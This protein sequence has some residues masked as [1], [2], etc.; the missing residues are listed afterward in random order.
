MATEITD[1]ESLGAYAKEHG[2][3]IPDQQPR[4]TAVSGTAK[5]IRLAETFEDAGRAVRRLTIMDNPKNSLGARVPL[6]LNVQCILPGEQA[7]SYRHSPG[8]TRFVGTTS[9]VSPG[10]DAAAP[11]ILVRPRVGP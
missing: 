8:A 11:P 1:L 4:E 3:V 7:R 2:L 6:R 9:C 10:R 5:H